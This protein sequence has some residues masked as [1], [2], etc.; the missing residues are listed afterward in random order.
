[1][2]LAER[3][4]DDMHFSVD[5]HGGAVNP[6]A[7]QYSRVATFTNDL[8]YG[9]GK[10]IQEGA[11]KHPAVRFVMPFVR[12]P[13]NIFRFSMQRTPGLARFTRQWKEALA[14]GNAERIA[15]VKAQEELGSMVMARPDCSLLQAASPALARLTRICARQLKDTGWQP[16]SVKI[17][18]TDRGFRIAAATP[19]SRCSAL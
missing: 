5:A 15:L 19:R 9:L 6:I 4:T 7:L 11:Q 17:P 16:Y 3:L 8:E 12:T 1:V 2:K 18:G 14:S 13:V 10:W